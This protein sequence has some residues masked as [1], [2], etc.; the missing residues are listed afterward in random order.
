[1][2]RPAPRVMVVQVRGDRALLRHGGSAT[3]A[4]VHDVAEFAVTGP[5][6]SQRAGGWVIAAD[7]VPD[8]MAA[9]QVVGGWIV[10]DA[11]EATPCR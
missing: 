8:V 3:R 9:A 6:W 4:E 2:S 1:M 5:V 11:K 7:A 10:R